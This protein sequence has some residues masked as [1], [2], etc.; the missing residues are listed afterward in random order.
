M[1]QERGWHNG[2]LIYE[3]E[4]SEK[5]IYVSKD[6]YD[7]AISAREEVLRQ[8]DFS[9]SRYHLWNKIMEPQICPW[10]MSI[11]LDVTGPR[12]WIIIVT[13]KLYILRE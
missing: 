8:T 3:S 9:L 2:F 10:M 1:D 11:I 4:K 7:A 13:F 12:K 6:E 5:E